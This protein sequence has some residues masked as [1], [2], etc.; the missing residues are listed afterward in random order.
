MSAT[1]K[2]LLTVKRRKLAMLHGATWGNT[3][4]SQEAEELRRKHGPEPLLWFPWERQGRIS[5]FWI[6]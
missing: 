5:M 6:G 2:L 1:E 4:V 3:G